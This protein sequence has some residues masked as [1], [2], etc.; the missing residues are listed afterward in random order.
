MHAYVRVSDMP[1]ERTAM[2]SYSSAACCDVTTAVAS[3]ASGLSVT[4]VGCHYAL[5]T[6]PLLSYET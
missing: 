2:Y 6:D 3:K 4:A 1:H 5:L